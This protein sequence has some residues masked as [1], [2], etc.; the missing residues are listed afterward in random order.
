MKVN[1]VYPKIPDSSYFPPKSCFVFEK[2]DGTNIHWIWNLQQGFFGFGTRRHRFSYDEKGFA[3]FAE[4]NRKNYL[5]SAAYYFNKVYEKGL[6]DIFRNDEKYKNSIVIVFTEYFGKS[7]FAGSHK[8]D[9]CKKLMLIDISID[10]KIITPDIF[11]KDFNQFPF[12]RLLYRG[13]YSGQLVEDVRHGKFNVDEGVVIKGVSHGNLY[14]VKVKTD[15]YMEK[16]KNFYKDN[17]KN[18]WE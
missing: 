11:L 13:K 12:A 7:S 6:D 8:P 10:N 4:E 5:S 3:E 17:W 14:M 1:L 18:Y 9:E 2:Y 16:L 15:N